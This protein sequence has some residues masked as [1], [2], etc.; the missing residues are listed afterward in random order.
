FRVEA[1]RLARK[2]HLL[3]AG[4]VGRNP[5]RHGLARRTQE[6]A[7]SRRGGALR[8]AA[9]AGARRPSGG[10][11]HG[12][13][14]VDTARLSPYQSFGRS[15]AGFNVTATL[16]DA[17]PTCTIDDVGPMP[18]IRPATV[19][20]LADVVRGCAA[21]GRPLFPLGGR[22]QLHLGTPPELPHGGGGVGVDLTAL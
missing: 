7:T 6:K 2:E 13:P 3:A 14:N 8:V 12:D 11:E 18:L 22:T 16:A 10:A 15:Q 9:G 20:E 21:D 19:A 5:V 1:Q 4:R 17:A